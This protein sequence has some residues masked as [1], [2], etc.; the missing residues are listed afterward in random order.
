MLYS[1]HIVM[2]TKLVHGKSQT[3]N[4]KSRSD[5]SGGDFQLAAGLNRE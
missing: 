4:W 3:G 1:I 2:I 5:P